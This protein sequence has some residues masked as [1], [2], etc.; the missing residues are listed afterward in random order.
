MKAP[1]LILWTVVVFC[2]PGQMASLFGQSV[3]AL[4]H[5][6][7]NAGDGS[8]TQARLEAQRQAMGTGP[9]HRS[10]EKDDSRT[11]SGKYTPPELPE[12]KKG[13]FVYGLAVFSDDGCNVTVGGSS[14]QQRLGQA[15]HLP[16]IGTSF[17]VLETVLAPGEP[18][19]ITVNYSNIIYNDD[20]KSH[21]Y[22]DIDGCTL[23]L[24]LIPAAI[25][26]D[27]NRDGII[28]LFRR[29]QGHHVPRRAFQV[30][31]Q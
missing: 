23:F 29:S 30:L 13:R 20:P 19:D 21:D 6:V 9:A 5:D 10:S 27:A 12:D 3:T 24:Y 7:S 28:C 14:I 18:I 8:I 2:L 16:D 25:A 17:Q 15:Q 4:I 26:V 1:C 31:A 22:P 11:F